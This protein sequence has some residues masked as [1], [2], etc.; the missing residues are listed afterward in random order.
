MIPTATSIDSASSLSK[1][2]FFCDSWRNL[3][4]EAARLRVMGF[5]LPLMME[6]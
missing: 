5:V 2:P 3:M 1:N 4:M 6:A